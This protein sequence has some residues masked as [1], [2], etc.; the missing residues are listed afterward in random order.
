MCSVMT[1]DQSAAFDCV[2]HKILLQKLKLYKLDDSAI[3]WLES[4]LKHRTQFVTVGRANSRMTGVS[5][6]VPQGSVLGPLLYSIFTNEM[7]E[8]I[9]DSTCT[10]QSHQNTDRLFNNECNSCGSLT[11]YAD[12]A[13]YV[14]GDR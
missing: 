11:Q 9:V 12:D 1:I 5:R 10:N 4:Y 3:M 7:S 14:T 13:T 2:S 6:G 8:V